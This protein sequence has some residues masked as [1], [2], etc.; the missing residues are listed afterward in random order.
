MN[1]D[2]TSLGDVNLDLLFLSASN[3]EMG[4]DE[5]KILDRILIKVGGGAANFSVWAARLGFKV[6]LIG[7]L[8]KDFIS[9]FILNELKKVG[10]EIRIAREDISAGITVAFQL[11][12]EKKLLLTYRG[13]NA[14][15]SMKHIHLNDIDGEVLYLSGYNL[16]DSLRKDFTTIVEKAKEKNMVVC[17]DPDI[18]A[19]LS[20]DRKEFF[21]VIKNVD[22]LFL[23]EDECRKIS[24]DLSWF[25]NRT[26]VVKRGSKGA[27][28]IEKGE[29]AEVEGIRLDKCYNTTG[30]GDVFNAGFLHH[31]YYGYDL[32]E[33]LEFANEQAVEYIKEINGIE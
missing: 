26:L 18:K 21:E 33:C 31:Y 19:K 29:R 10:I 30:A 7:C 25:K 20:F 28:A 2:I 14:I 32:K 4:E 23:N 27:F 9:D 22:V 13:S 8:G 24:S 16:L 6:R 15:F 12:N 11:P 5:Q 17:L 3:F 1:I